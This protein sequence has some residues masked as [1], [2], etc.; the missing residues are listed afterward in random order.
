MAKY[1]KTVTNFI[2]LS[3]RKYPIANLLDSIKEFPPLNEQSSTFDDIND[4]TTL[5]T[6]SDIESNRLKS[7]YF[8]LNTLLSEIHTEMNKS[9][10]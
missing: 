7:E 6:Q 3:K 9:I 5:N 2:N 1:F 10:S 4:I 8:R